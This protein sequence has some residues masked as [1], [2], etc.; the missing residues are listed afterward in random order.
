M[1][2]ILEKIAKKLFFSCE[3]ATFLIEKK[4]SGQ[5]IRVI[6]NIRLKGH[7]AMCKWCRAYEKK[8]TI[9]ESA[10]L[11]ISKKEEESIVDIELESFK[12]QLKEKM[13]Q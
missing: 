10:M 5:T 8:V 3:K 2:S 9:I 13:F 1:I 4:A 12:I 7:L 6:E 11:N